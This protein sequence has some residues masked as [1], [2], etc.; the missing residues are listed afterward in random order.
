MLL[1]GAT[2]A[3]LSAQQSIYMTV[4]PIKGDQPAPHAGEFRLNSFAAAATSAA[5]TGA[6]G[7]GL[8]VSKPEF[9]AVQV[10][11]R[12]N[13]LA[14]A[15]F[16]QSIAA[17][18]RLPSIEIRFYNSTN[19]LVSKTIFENVLLTKVT[20]EGSD[21][22]QQTLEFVYSKSRWFAPTDA[23]GQTAPV[24]VACWDQASA[25]RC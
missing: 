20:T 21:E 14:S 10:S 25:T 4:D 11:M 9:S 18:T 15:S 12:Y 8:T 22:A 1:I 17:G 6:T 23:A 5:T 3:T 19:R 24:Q 7:T 16:Y 13:P 2:A